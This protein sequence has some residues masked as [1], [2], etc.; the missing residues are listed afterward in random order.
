MRLLRNMK[1]L[2]AFF[3]LVDFG[4]IVYW[5]ITLF[6]LIPEELLF[7]DYHNPLLVVWNWS[8]FPLDIFV[9]MTG[10]LSLYLNRKGHPLWIQMALVSLVLTFCSGLQAIAFWSIQGFFDP[11]WW[12][13][14]LFLLM[15]PFFFIPGLMLRLLQGG[16]GDMTLSRKGM[17]MSG[18][19]TAE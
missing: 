14:N 9:S 13:P 11:L 19:I 7:Q 8:F 10:L 1:L 3:L 18:Q 6:H 12:A 17:G 15:Y 16:V 2:R 5:G 4:F